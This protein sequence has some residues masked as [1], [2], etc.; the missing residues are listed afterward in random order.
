MTLPLAP[1][2]EKLLLYQLLLILILLVIFFFAAALFIKN[3]P[4]KNFYFIEE[5]GLKWKVSKHS[6]TAKREP[7]CSKHQIELMEHKKLTVGFKEGLVSYYCPICK[8]YIVKDLPESEIRYILEIVKQK[9]EAIDS[10]HNIA[11]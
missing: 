3:R 6:G 4:Y 10:K 8:K 11:F 2:P 1:L 5:A 9:A 7:F